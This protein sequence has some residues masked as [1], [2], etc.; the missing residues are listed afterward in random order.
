MKFMA[1]LR[2][3]R[4]PLVM[5]TATLPPSME[6]ELFRAF[7]Y[8]QPI[9]VRALTVRPEIQYTINEVEGNL[10]EALAD[11]LQL[12]Q[13]KSQEQDRATV[14]CLTKDKVIKCSRKL[15]TTYIRPDIYHADMNVLECTRCYDH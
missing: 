7:A 3:I 5:L 9:V 13:L 8:Q 4:A 2:V 10:L 11:V 15:E 1:D 6:Q 12:W 14:Y